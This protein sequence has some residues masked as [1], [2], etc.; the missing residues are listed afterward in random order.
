MNE[1]PLYQCHKRVRACKIKAVTRTATGWIIEPEEGFLE[2]IPV[3]VDYVTKHQPA[4]G[5]YF[6]TYEDGYR[7]YS[8]GTA[9]EAGY[10]PIDVLT[11]RR[12]QLVQQ[13]ASVDAAIA[14][15][16][17]RTTTEGEPT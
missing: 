10:T 2:P 12:E 7:S 1:L 3:S 5:G 9:F 6:V 13:L 4:P 14:A 17:A 11:D 8:P 15:A 16:A